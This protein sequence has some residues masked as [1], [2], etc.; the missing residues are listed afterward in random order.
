MGG[1]GSSSPLSMRGAQPK[2]QRG[3]L[4]TRVAGSLKEALGAKGAPM[5][6]ARAYGGANP[7]YSEDYS[8]YSW[9]CQRCV[10]AY[11][12]RRRGYD[13]TAQPTY[14]GDVL[15][16]STAGG[17]GR[18]MGAFQGAK[19]VMAGAGT[20]DGA[21]SRMKS[22]MQAWG[23]GSRAIVR[24]GWKNSRSG[25]VFNAE[26]RGGKI[27]YVDA[28]TGDRVNIN[29]YLGAAN[30]STVRLVRTDNLRFSE[31]AKKSLAKARG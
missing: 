26:N 17:N 20:V 12:A 25:H 5:S 21:K 1:R 10:V 2:F 23:D 7:Y 24:V 6:M 11:E 13:V 16:Q 3:A 22:Q 30:T 15:P 27:H 14:A 28:Q 8:E 4:G 18:W 9:N 31:R 29:Q 19:S